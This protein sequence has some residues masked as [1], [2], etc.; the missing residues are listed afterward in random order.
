MPTEE[1]KTEMLQYDDILNEIKA[2]NAQTDGI[3]T[4]KSE[5]SGQSV[6]ETDNNP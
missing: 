3:L 6:S 1:R 4:S 5:F 2:K